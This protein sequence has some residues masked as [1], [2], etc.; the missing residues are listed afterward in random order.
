MLLILVTY[1]TIT[2]ANFWRIYFSFSRSLL[3]NMWSY[4]NNVKTQILRVLFEE[5]KR[6]NNAIYSVPALLYYS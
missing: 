4:L 3:W 6:R 2:V 1:G 5:N